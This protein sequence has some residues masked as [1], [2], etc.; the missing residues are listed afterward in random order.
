[1]RIDRKF[2]EK[3]EEQVKATPEVRER[4]ERGDIQGAEEMVAAELFDKPEDFFNLEKLRKAVQLDRRVTLREI[5]AKAFG[6]IERFKT[7]D[8]LLE[9]ELAKFVS[10]HKPDAAHM[11]VIQQYFKAHV[12][13]GMVRA[14][15]DAGEFGRLAHNPKVSLADIRALEQWRDIITEYV[16]GY[17]L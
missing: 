15:V 3:F 9:E 13:D 10:I 1:M 16:K 11:P 2:F 14:V 12:T 5:L 7:K 17:S 8:E 6:E 4:F